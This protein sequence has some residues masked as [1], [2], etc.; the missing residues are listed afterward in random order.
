MA[1]VAA[2]RVGHERVL[3]D[4]QAG[5]HPEHDQHQHQQQFAAGPPQQ[6]R[7]SACH[8][9]AQHHHQHQAQERVAD[10]G[11]PIQAR[12]QQAEHL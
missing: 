5:A 3:G 4:G 9:E 8:K 1:A 12:I 7:L 10:G 11:A 2:G 6:A